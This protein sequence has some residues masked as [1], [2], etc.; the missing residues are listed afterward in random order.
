[1]YFLECSQPLIS[2]FSFIHFHS[3]FLIINM[4]KIYVGSKNIVVRDAAYLNELI[5]K[6]IFI[7]VCKQF[8]TEEKSGTILYHC[9]LKDTNTNKT[10]K[11][12]WTL[13]EGASD[14]IALGPPTD[15]NEGLTPIWESN[16]QLAAELKAEINIT[17]AYWNELIRRANTLGGEV[18]SEPKLLTSSVALK[19]PWK[20]VN[21]EEY[22]LSFDKTEK[23]HKIMVGCGYFNPER[24]GITLQLSNFTDKTAEAINK[25]RKRSRNEE[26]ADEEETLV[27]DS[28]VIPSE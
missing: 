21:P 10:L 19:W 16:C 20:K 14:S 4:N 13:P 17:M 6:G 25:K 3:L 15:F 2:V 1:M 9:E 27:S 18:T 23:C 24:Y 8:K 22:F 28:V 26:E 12:A 7:P 5:S 11:V